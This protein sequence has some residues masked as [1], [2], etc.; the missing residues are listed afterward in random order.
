M[1]TISR[2]SAGA[3]KTFLLTKTYIDMLFSAHRAKHAHRR[4]LAVTFTKKATAEMKQRI[5]REL[6]VLAT[7]SQESGAKTQDQSPFAAD[8]KAK[9]NLS[10]AQLQ[11]QAQQILFDLLQDYSAFS[12]STIDS[13]FQ[14]VIRTFSRELG[15]SG[16]YNLELDTKAIQQTAVDDFFFQLSPAEDKAT[17]DALLAI[18]EDNLANDKTWN[19]KADILA[20]S[21]E[22]FREAVMQ[23]KQQLFTF[24]QD[25]TAVEAYKKAQYAICQT[26]F[27]SYQ[28][29][30][31]QV[32]EYMHANGL[33]EDMFARY[34]FNPLHFERDEI[35]EAI[36][37]QPKTFFNFIEKEDKSIAKKGYAFVAEHE[38]ALRERCRPLYRLLTDPQHT[39]PLLTAHA[40]LGK[41]PIL[42]LLGKVAACID[43]KNKELNRL[44][45][46]DT[47]A[48][49]NDVVQ[50]NEQSPFIYEKIGT[51]IRHFLID[52]F[53]DTSAMQWTSFRPL[54]RESLATDQDNLVVG[55]VKQ[56]IYRFRNSDYSLMLRGINSDFPHAG[57]NNLAGNW[58]SCE[59]VVE[60]NNA[61]F[62]ELAAALNAEMNET[63]DGAF[64]AFHDVIQEVY[65]QHTQQPM[66]AGKSPDKGFVQVQFSPCEGRKEKEWRETV[67]ASLPDVMADIQRRGIPLGRVACLV[68]NNKEALPIAETLIQAGYKVMSN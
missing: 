50:A 14:Q 1:L 65:T 43:E 9:Y 68:R 38:T 15:L 63:L 27:K 49:L 34:V 5:V 23:N 51:R 59:H 53:Q 44:P 46:S 56:S 20:L 21:A 37:K 3:G 25:T 30:V 58:R 13:F 28:D 48:L 32:R 57:H 12:V 31:A 17:F 47:N 61:L 29:T 33:E 35:L 11:E 64:P 7:P 41:Y 66:L 67:L 4:I 42:T 6:S 55:D 62:E 36:V 60:A 10:D 45:I 24:L 18:I 52:E 54:I 22:L 2:A 39:Q 16:K 19:P 26:Y 40:I 8:L